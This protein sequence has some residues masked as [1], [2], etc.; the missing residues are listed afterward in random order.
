MIIYFIIKIN[1]HAKKK[2]FK[3][4]SFKTL[5]LANVSIAKLKKLWLMWE[6]YSS[7]HVTKNL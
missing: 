2:R 4:Y 6:E 7:P 1:Y 5:L 3:K